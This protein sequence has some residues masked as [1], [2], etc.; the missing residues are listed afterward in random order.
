[1]CVG[2]PRTIKVQRIEEENNKDR[3]RWELAAVKDLLRVGRGG[4]GKG[5]AMLEELLLRWI[6]A[7][8]QRDET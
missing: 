7:E 6:W 8:L 4:M 1:M 2:L 3:H 5:K